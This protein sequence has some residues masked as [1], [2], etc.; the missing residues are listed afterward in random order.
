VSQDDN[1]LK[2]WLKRSHALHATYKWSRMASQVPLASWMDLHRTTSIWK[3]L[4]NTMLPAKR[5]ISA[6]DTMITVERDRLPGAV[7]ECGVWSGG[8]IG[9]MALASRRAGNG[10]RRFHL[11]DSFAGLPQPSVEDDE[12][13]TDYHRKNPDRAP[14]QDASPR[15]IGACVG[16]DAEAVR[17]FLTRRLGIDPA[18]L[19]FHVGWFQ[20]TVPAARESMGPLAVLRIDGDWYEST[21]ICLDQLYDRVVDG[22]FVIVDD[23]G[24]FTGCRKAVDEAFAE[25]GISASRLVDVDG[26]CVFLRK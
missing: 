21:K 12:V 20:E 3:V 24:T 1:A 13:F 26:E 23:Y 6:Y 22:G 16:A 4:P 14:D 11:F 19:V 2:R 18:Q 7:A 15:S 5:L 9:L 25:R 10:S 17:A 8:G